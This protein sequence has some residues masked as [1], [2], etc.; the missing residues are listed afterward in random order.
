MQT[1]S[2]DLDGLKYE[3]LER[4]WEEWKKARENLDNINETKFEEEYILNN[5]NDKYILNLIEEKSKNNKLHLLK[6]DLL[7]RIGFKPQFRT[8][9]Y[10]LPKKKTYWQE[11]TYLI[12][13]VL[14]IS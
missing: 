8:L 6:S 7:L 10:N 9:W 13:V 14:F 11:H 1:Y 12:Y 5:I 2:D 3:V 4:S